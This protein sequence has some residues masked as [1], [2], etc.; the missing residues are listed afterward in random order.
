[1]VSLVHS[2]FDTAGAACVTE[3]SSRNNVS[4]NFSFTIYCAMN[5]IQEDADRST[6]LKDVFINGGNCY[7]RNN[8]SSSPSVHVNTKD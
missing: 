3:A 2:F 5:V 6:K 1:M 4:A 7:I 8:D